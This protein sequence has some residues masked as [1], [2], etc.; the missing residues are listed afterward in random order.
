MNCFKK[1]TLIAALAGLGMG[2][3]A[4]AQVTFPSVAGLYLYDEATGQS[5]NV[6]AVGGVAQFVG[7]V[8]D[9]TVIVNSTGR[10]LAGGANP[11]LDLVVSEAIAGPNA[12]R[13]DVY[14]SDGAFGPTAGQYILYSTGPSGGGPVVSCAGSS[15]SFFGNAVNLGGGMDAYPCVTNVTGIINSTSYYL[16]LE[17]VISTTA[18]TSE[19]GVDSTLAVVPEPANLFSRS[20]VLLPI[21]IGA[22]RLL[23]KCRQA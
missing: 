10:T 16:T 19:I 7:T 12:T 22:V 11:I 9:Y 15:T 17:D 5:T 18:S 6:A 2:Q 4:S 23:R 3:L 21:G 13:L 1:T 14:Y 20:L 8:G